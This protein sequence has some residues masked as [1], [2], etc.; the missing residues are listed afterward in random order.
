MTEDKRCDYCKEHGFRSPNLCEDC[1]P[2]D[3]PLPF[4][5]SPD[6]SKASHVPGFGRAGLRI[7]PLPT[8][9]DLLEALKQCLGWIDAWDPNFTQ[10]DEWP[11]YRAA[12]NAAIAKASL[13]ATLPLFIEKAEGYA[14]VPAEC[15]WESRYRD[16]KA[17]IDALRR[18]YG[19]I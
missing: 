14:L 11:K 8:A 1:R 12:F 13:P 10:D 5:A 15:Y 6:Y 9:P 16:A 19:D 2:E 18:K 7:E 17:E 4:T 3:R